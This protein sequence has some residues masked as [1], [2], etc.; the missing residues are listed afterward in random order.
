MWE[1]KV[2]LCPHVLEKSVFDLVSK[3]V[4]M[5]W[6]LIRFFCFQKGAQIFIGYFKLCFFHVQHLL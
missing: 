5:A 2:L 3:I 1:D 6:E 4:E